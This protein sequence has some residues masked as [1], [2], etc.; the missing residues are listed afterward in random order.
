MNCKRCSTRPALSEERRAGASQD[1]GTELP[2]N[3]CFRCIAEDPAYSAAAIAWAVRKR[4]ETIQRVRN[5]ISRPLEMIDR[6]VES[7]QRGR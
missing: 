4:A 5:T 2:P 1:L 3:L 6:W 7:L